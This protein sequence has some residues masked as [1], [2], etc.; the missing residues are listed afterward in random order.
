[1]LWAQRHNPAW[2]DVR[3]FVAAFRRLETDA[4]AWE[5]SDGHWAAELRRAA[6]GQ[7][8]YLALWRDGTLLGTY[9]ARRGWRPAARSKPRRLAQVARQLAFAS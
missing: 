3:T 1:M 4:H 9:D 8:V 5:S 6:Y 2:L 7:H